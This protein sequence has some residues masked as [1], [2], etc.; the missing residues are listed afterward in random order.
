ML[1]VCDANASMGPPHDGGGETWRRPWLSGCR[2]ASMGPPHDGG[3]EYDA[4]NRTPIA[5][6]A[7]MGPPHDGGGEPHIKMLAMGAAMLQ[8]GRLTM[9]AER[10]MGLPGMSSA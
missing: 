10:M 8:W 6:L 9:E 4:E 3:G 5:D 1:Q 7:S 2:A